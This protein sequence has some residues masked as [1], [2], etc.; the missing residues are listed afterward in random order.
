MAGSSGDWDVGP[1]SLSLPPFAGPSDPQIFIGPDVPPIV[2]VAVQAHGRTTRTALAVVIYAKSYD[3]TGGFLAT[4]D[5]W[6]DAVTLDTTTKQLGKVTGVV[7]DLRLFYTWLTEA[8]LG[9][10]TSGTLGSNGPYFAGTDSFLVFG[11]DKFSPTVVDSYD[12]TDAESGYTS[13]KGSMARGFRY[14]NFSTANTGG[15]GAAT[16]VFST[17]GRVFKSG[18]AYEIIVSGRISTSAGTVTA[19]FQ[20]RHGGTTKINFGGVGPEIGPA[21]TGFTL[22][23]IV[24]NTS[25]S[26]VTATTDLLITPSAGTVNWLGAATYP[27][28]L[29]IRDCGHADYYPSAPTA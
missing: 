4:G 2:Q 13:G 27:R 21:G 8:I 23:Q 16:S 20:Y 29:E 25:L 14:G 24:R 1:S 7:S 17:A 18:R 19:N 22:R 9:Y 5:Y 26:D 10:D 3:P 6:F 11:G 28:G 15:L 12:P